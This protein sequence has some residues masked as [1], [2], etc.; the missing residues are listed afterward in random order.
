MDDVLLLVA[1]PGNVLLPRRQRRADRVHAGNDALLVLVYLGEDGSADAGH[2][3]GVDH[4]VGG[5]GELDAD[6]RHGRTD[7]AHR[8]RH[9]VHGASAHAAAEDLLQLA[10]HL[11][12]L[13]PVVGGAGVVARERA[14]E[15][16]VFHPGDVVGRGAGVKA[17]WPLLVIEW[18]EGAGF[19]QPIAQP[20]VF[21]LG[22]VDP[23]DGCGLG[24]IGHLLHP[25]DEVLVRRGRL[26]GALSGHWSWR[27]GEQDFLWDSSLR[28]GAWAVNRIRP[29]SDIKRTDDSIT[30]Q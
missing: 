2:D 28:F 19:D 7:G 23:V 11:V 12:R 21:G 5:V 15:G 18:E 13:D 20:V 29:R 17:A 25:A 3:A 24:E 10:V 30:G 26:G 6:L 9:D 8:E 27:P 22:A 16:A 4:G 14:D 1:G